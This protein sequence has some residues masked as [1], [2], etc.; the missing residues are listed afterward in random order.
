MSACV[1]THHHINLLV[2]AAID[3]RVAIK[4]ARAVLAEISTI[5][6]GQNLGHLLLAENIRSVLHRYA[7]AGQDGETEYSADLHAYR[8]RHY[9]IV[10]GDFRQR[11]RYN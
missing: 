11:G 5:S 1:V 9:A 7:T 10:S 3:R 8:F 2:S 6:N 4:F